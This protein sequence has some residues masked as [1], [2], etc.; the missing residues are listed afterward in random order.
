[1]S[2]P[3]AATLELEGPRVFAITERGRLIAK[4]DRLET[5]IRPRK[6]LEDM[7]WIRDER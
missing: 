5:A 2:G 3:G 1:M 4:T 7:F 6:I